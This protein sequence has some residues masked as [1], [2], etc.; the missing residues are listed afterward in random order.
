[1]GDNKL[2]GVSE[3]VRP[4]SG[5]GDVV[6]WLKKSKISCQVKEKRGCGNLSASVFGRGCIGFALRDEEENQSNATSIVKK[7]KEAFTESEFA[8]YG[9]LGRVKWLE[10]KWMYL[11]TR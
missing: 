10:N 11:L 7:L 3:V 5:D 9:K 4:F 1:M 8:A 6:A 2:K